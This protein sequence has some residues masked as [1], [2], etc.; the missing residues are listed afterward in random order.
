MPRLDHI[1]EHLFANPGAELVLESNTTGVYRGA[2]PELPVFRQMLRTGQILLLFADVVPRDES[3]AL[4]AGSPVQ[5]RYAAPRGPLDV[6][7]EMKGSDIVVRVKC[8]PEVKPAAVAPPPAAAPLEPPS[9]VLTQLIS[10]LP[11]RRASH[12]HLSS[13]Q[14]AFLRVEGELV[15]LRELGAFSHAQIREALAALAPPQLAELVLSH[16]RF[17]FTHVT[18][19]AVFHVRAQESRAGLTVVVRYLP[20]QVP[21]VQSLGLPPDFVDGMRG[22]GLWVLAGSAGQGTSTSLAAL[23]QGVLNVRPAAVYAVESSIEYVLSPGQGLAQ[24]L[25]VGTHV[26]SFAEA[27]VQARAIDADLT[28]VGELEDPEA[29]VQAIG[30]ADRGRL[31]LGA[32]HARTSVEA[33]QKMLMMLARAPLQAQ[34]GHVLRGVFAQQLV[35]NTAGGRSLAWELLPGTEAVRALVRSSS[36]A[37]LAAHRSHTLESNLRDLVL[38]GE[39]EADVAT[40][41]SPDR[42]WLE[43]ELA[44]A[45]HPRAA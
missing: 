24:Q 38:R 1:V 26:E 45:A 12:L 20:R 29:L 33:V 11:E 44:R 19:D 7:M 3:Q 39:L 32:L 43:R 15:P 25:E 34:L 17:D 30:L 9:L 4:L 8:P 6:F 16:T 35:P 14:P 36:V 22:T 13:G 27:L 2:G 18:A 21:S 31:V 23:A 28:V 5:F 40:A 37:Q 41:L 10:E 42:E